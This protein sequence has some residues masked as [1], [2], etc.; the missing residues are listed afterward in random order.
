M[1]MGKKRKPQPKCVDCGKF[2]RRPKGGFTGKRC[3]ACNRTWECAR[4][5]A[6]SH[7]RMEDPVKREQKNANKRA[8]RRRRME[9]P[10]KRE[11]CN[12][13]K[14]ENLRR[15]MEDPVQR[16]KH[17]ANSRANYHR[18]ARENMKLAQQRALAIVKRTS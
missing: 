14:R 16:A 15:R 1:T 11:Q 17:N 13:C 6:S 7:R 8:I 18:M 3:V 5:R 12:A 4:D 10:V 2:I 9:D